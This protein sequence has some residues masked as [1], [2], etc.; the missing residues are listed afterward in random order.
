[1][2]RQTR[3]EIGALLLAAAV[4]AG[5]G[6]GT[7][8]A[9]PTTLTSAKPVTTDAVHALVFDATLSADGSIAYF[10]GVGPNGPG[11]YSVP[12]SGGPV[13][14]VVEGDPLAA[15]MGIALSTDGKTLY[16]ADS[17]ATTTTGDLGLIFSLPIAGG[18]PTP[19]KG[20][21]DVEPR[22]LDIASENG[23]DQIYFTGTVNGEVGLQKVPAS[24]G[25]VATLAKGAPFIDPEGVVVASSD[26]TTVYVVDAIASSLTPGSIIAYDGTKATEFLPGV[27][28]GYPSGISVSID[29]KTVIVSTR[30]PDKGQSTLLLVDVESKETS[31]FQLASEYEPGGLHRAGMAEQFAWVSYDPSGASVYLVK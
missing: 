21:D 31:P 10:T 30:D 16:V 2:S 29:G 9:P 6:K 8:P 19:V 14:T 27:D 1:M 28:V 18:S 20:T 22:G 23:S 5:C 17:G 24:G 13:G 3:L 25:T 26:G 4:A 15:P 11:V 7:T 12:A